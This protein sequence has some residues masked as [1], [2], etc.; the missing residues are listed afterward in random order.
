MTVLTV[1]G[2][3]QIVNLPTPENL[4]QSNKISKQVISNKGLAYVQDSVV[5]YNSTDGTDWVYDEKS[6]TLS[7]TSDSMNIASQ[8]S[9]DYNSSTSE[10]EKKILMSFGYSENS[11]YSIFYPDNTEITEIPWNSNIM[12]WNTDTMLYYHYYPKISRQF[13]IVYLDKLIDMNW[14]YST[15]QFTGGMRVDIETIDDS[16]YSSAIERDWDN[17]SQSFVNAIKHTFQYDANNYLQQWLKQSWNTTTSAWD[18]SEQNFFVY[19]NGF[20]VQKIAQNWSGSAWNNDYKEIYT[21]DAN[22]NKTN[23]TKYTW[24][25]S[26]WVN[27]KKTDYTYDSNNNR[28]TQT[29]YNWDNTNSVWLGT[30]KY[31]YQYDA[32]NNNTLYLY[33]TWDDINSMWV[34]QYRYQYTFDSNNNMTT[35]VR[36]YWD[37]TN[38]TWVNNYKDE[39]TY[40]SNNN[41]TLY[42]E[43]DWDN[44]NTVW[45]PSY[46]KEYTYDSNNK[47]TLYQS[48]NYN[49]SNSTWVN[50]SKETSTYDANSN[51][52]EDIY[53]EWNT[54]NSSWDNSSKTVYYYSGHQVTKIDLT[55]DVIVDVFPNP[56]SGQIKVKNDNP[57]EKIQLYSQDGKLLVDKNH[58]GTFEKQIDISRLNQGI[59]ILK[60]TDI[61]GTVTSRKIMKQ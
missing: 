54:T 26:N 32:N 10:W 16:L 42:I 4:H 44:T 14:N 15:N 13:S 28:L 11:D 48:Y 58:I 18:N 1:L 43:Y 21:Y 47:Q 27:Y 41:E 19:T 59:Y 8:Y 53:Y 36:Q 6:N 25:G 24:D 3:G 45:N 51:L 39:Y 61:N 22:N 12:N 2:F 33:Q 29:R 7:I 37:N 46:K 30:Y 35:L 31:S 17:A 38:S 20:L 52:T 57:I 60:V 34:N 49:Q 9:S 50:E 56:T 23:Y 40:D 5:Y 55:Q